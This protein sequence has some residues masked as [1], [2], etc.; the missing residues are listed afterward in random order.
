[1]ENFYQPM[2]QQNKFFYQNNNIPNPLNF[3]TIYH[4]SNLPTHPQ[5]F[6]NLSSLPNVILNRKPK[7]IFNSNNF[8]RSDLLRNDLYDILRNEEIRE[9]SIL[10]DSK[11]RNYQ[12]YPNP[13]KYEVKF[14]PLH[15]TKEKINGRMVSHEIPNPVI[16][17]RLINVRYIKLEEVI[18]PLFNKVIST[19]EPINDAII[20]SW[21][22]DVTRPLIDN[23]YTVLSIHEYR[24]ISD[25]IMSTNDVLSDS[26]ATIY[27]N[28]RI[29]DTHYS[30]R[31]SNGIKIFQL[32]E[33]PTIDSWKIN[34]MDPYGCPLTVD[35]IDKTI[36]S[37][38]ECFCIEEGIESPTCFRHNLL[39]PLNPIF[40]HHL[41][42]KV[43]VIEPK[44][45]NF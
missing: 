1:M 19:K 28:E 31:T 41:H 25:N 27:F 8:N 26:F 35:H 21:K 36:L 2:T 4:P 18:L 42:F 13:F 24:D 15:T 22:I 43:G 20:E 40:Q 3:N 33:L 37:N 39:H 23:L 38:C 32:N 30:G 5:N 9:Y 16:S 14:G 11:D 10:I 44:L 45:N 7:T 12:I 29:S 6:D 17:S 34:F